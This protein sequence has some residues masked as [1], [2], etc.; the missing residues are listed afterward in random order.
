MKGKIDPL[1]KTQPWKVLSVFYPL[2]SVLHRLELDGTVET[3]GRQ[4]VFHEDSKN[5]WYDLV[6]ALRGVIQFHELAAS[7]HSLPIDLSAMVRFANKLEAGSPI[8]ESDLEAMKT[9]INSCKQQAMKLRVS[10]AT[11]IVDTVRI[12]AELDRLKGIAA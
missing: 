10:E 7:R 2:E 12:S 5:G 8:F 1:L 3:A 9:C 11:S 4:V 6:A